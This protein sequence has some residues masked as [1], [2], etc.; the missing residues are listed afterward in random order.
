MS[1]MFQGI[2][3]S[4]FVNNEVLCQLD[5]MGKKPIIKVPGHTNLEWH[6]PLHVL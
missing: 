2:N 6:F 5:V 1:Q 4:Q 3:A